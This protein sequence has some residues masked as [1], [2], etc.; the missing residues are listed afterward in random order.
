MLFVMPYN[1]P[2]STGPWFDPDP[3]MDHLVFAT[4]IQKSDVFFALSSSGSMAGEINNL[5]SSLQTTVIPGILS[6]MP[7]IWFGVGRFED[8]HSCAHNMAVL[9]E[10]T[11]D[12]TA[13]EAALTGWGTC[14]GD[15]PFT[16][17]LHVLATGDVTP[18]LG[19]GNVVPTH[20]TCTPP[21]SIGWPCFRTD[22]QPIVVQFGDSPF[23]EAWTG[24]SPGYTLDQAVTALNSISAKYIGVNSGSSRAD[25]EDIAIG[26]GSADVMGTPLVLDV[27]S[28]GSGLGAQLVDAIEI[29]AHQ[30]P[31]DVSFRL[32][33]DPSDMVDTVSE[34]VDYV[35]PS[36]AGG[37][38][39]PSD[40][41]VICVG[42][43]DVDDRYPPL[44]GRP[45]SFSDV[46]PGTPVC[47]DVYVKQNWTVRARREPLVFLL[48][49][50]VIAD[51]ITVVDTIDVYFLVPP[52]IEGVDCP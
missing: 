18:F 11:D 23:S 17:Y 30:V 20:W 50:D 46:L 13:V 43:L 8:C 4:D 33:D 41:T 39:D 34:F 9:Q 1:E 31:V 51:G 14:G 26:T 45:D 21:G 42:G 7:G 37:W 44:D 48:E 28:D 32:R 25:M 38:P 49:I 27:P 5:R 29:L 16:Q 36:V 35:E 6:E 3:T 10:M 15:N 12:I 2:G 52:V 40:P 47:F 22:A 24:C 19:W